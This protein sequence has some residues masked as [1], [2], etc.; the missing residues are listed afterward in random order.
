MKL[1]WDPAYA[2]AYK[3]QVSADA[4]NWLDIYS[5]TTGNGGIDDLTGL[6]GTGRYVRVLTSAVATTFGVSL[7]SFEVYP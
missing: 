3:I 5:T 6:S 7:W 2:T 4:A 1:S